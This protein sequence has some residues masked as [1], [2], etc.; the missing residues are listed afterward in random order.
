MLCVCEGEGGGVRVC[1][2]GGGRVCNIIMIRDNNYNY[3]NRCM[4]MYPFVV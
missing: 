1:V 2:W 3:N 4:H